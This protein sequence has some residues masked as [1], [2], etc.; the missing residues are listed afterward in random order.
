MQYRSLNVQEHPVIELCMAAATYLHQ[1]YLGQQITTVRR[2]INECS[3]QTLVLRAANRPLRPRILTAF[4][5][6]NIVHYYMHVSIALPGRKY[7]LYR[8]ICW[9][10]CLSNVI[11]PQLLAVTFKA[12]G[13][14]GK[15]YRGN[16]KWRKITHSFRKQTFAFL[17]CV[18]FILKHGC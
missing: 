9:T 18:W 6:D 8:H 3:S 1:T 15:G 10:K 2:W 16:T 17:E 12:A 14:L 7:P 11:L 13:K 5:A 4:R